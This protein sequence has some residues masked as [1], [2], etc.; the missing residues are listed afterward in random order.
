ML[1]PAVIMH[2]PKS[3]SAYFKRPNPDGLG[4]FPTPPLWPAVRHASSPLPRPPVPATRPGR[5]GQAW[6][7]HA[8]PLGLARHQP[9]ALAK[10]PDFPAFW[11]PALRGDDG[12]D[13][14]P[15]C[16]QGPS[17]LL[18]AVVTWPVLL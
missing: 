7:H 2:Q 6:V 14:R 5:K 18:S 12:S 1:F 8:P 11:L 16:S 10:R 17:A 4:G 15:G 13:S 9:Q 3:F